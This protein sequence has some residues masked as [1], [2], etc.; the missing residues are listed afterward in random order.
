MS[1]GRNAMDL[2]FRRNGWMNCNSVP[3][4]EDWRAQWN[5]TRVRLTEPRPLEKKLLGNCRD[6]SLLLA[7]IAAPPGSSQPAPVVDS[8][9]TL[10]PI[11]SKIIG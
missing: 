6:H 2:R 10:C 5:W 11:I 4:S 3:W 8:A 9:P 1:F 7:S